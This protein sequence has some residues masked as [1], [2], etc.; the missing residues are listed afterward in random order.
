M[1]IAN[2]LQVMAFMG[3]SGYLAAYLM[4][5]YEMSAGEKRLFH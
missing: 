4:Q 1:L 2:C 5:I 3:M